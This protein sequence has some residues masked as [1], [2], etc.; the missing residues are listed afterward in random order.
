M[1]GAVDY[2]Q[3]KG[4][5][6]QV[7][8]KLGVRYTGIFDHISQEDQT[9]C[10]AQVYNHGTEDRPTARKLAG[11]ASTLGWV[12]FHTESIES[13][14]LVE[15]YVP[16]GQ[17]EPI[18]PI[19]ASVSQSA[20]GASG[21]SQQSSQPPSSTP[22]ASSSRSPSTSAP[23]QRHDLPPKPSGAA[24]SAATALDRVQASLQDLSVDS[25]SRQPARRR[26]AAPAQAIEV[27]DAEFDFTAGTQAFEK[28]RE[29][30]R[31]GPEDS[32]EDVGEP[33]HPPHPAALSPR[34]ES[35]DGSLEPANGG[36]PAAPGGKKISSVYNKGSFFDGLSG[37]SSRISRNE[38]RSRNYDT[39]G[40]AGGSDQY[41]G[42]GGGYG[43]RGRGGHARGGGGGY[44][45]GYN[46]GQGGYG[47]QQ[48]G[49]GGRGR[50]G[51]RGG[52]G[53]PQRQGFEEL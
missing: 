24:I 16:P 15:N 18:D 39:F 8:S 53:Q 37:E 6:F 31:K 32:A 43:G 28:E 23:S 21:P 1:A 13:L 34:A 17:E 19:L 35:E 5:P 51:Q 47:R 48:G 49:Y 20:P 50:G 41:G 10:L 22:P 33:E 42:G 7:I 3:F 9:I 12:R 2:S 27:P 44:R 29:S 36:Q 52:Y 40:E 4:K 30:R 38:E 46:Q 45:G 14:A 26:P 11:S 25:G